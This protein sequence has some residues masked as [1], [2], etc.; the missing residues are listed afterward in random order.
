MYYFAHII[1]IP[2][3]QEAQ[4]ITLQ[5]EKKSIFCLAKNAPNPFLQ[6]KGFKQTF[7]VKCF[8]YPIRN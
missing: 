1:T 8:Y 5:V 3:H 2:A 7:Q 4:D 6:G